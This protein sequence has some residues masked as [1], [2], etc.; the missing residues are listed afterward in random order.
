MAASA[1]YLINDSIDVA[2]DR[3]HPVKRNRPIAAVWCRC[4]SRHRDVGG[5][6]RR[7][8]RDRHGDLDALLIVIAVY[9]AVQL[10]YCLGLKHEPV[11]DICIVASGFLIRAIAGARPRTS[12]CPSGSCWR[13]ASVRCSWWPA[14]ATPSSSWPA[15][16]R[17]DP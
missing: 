9:I 14:S 8:A 12:R 6:V 17:Q 13:P 3:V 2:E 10:G 1:V 5:A 7:L 4:G 16:P 15:A 11:I